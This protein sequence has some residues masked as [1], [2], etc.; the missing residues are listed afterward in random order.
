[1]CW[2]RCG[3][4][5]LLAMAAWGRA[6][7]QDFYGV[8]DSRESTDLMTRLCNAGRTSRSIITPTG[9]A[10]TATQYTIPADTG[11]P[12]VGFNGSV[13]FDVPAGP[14]T[15][16]LNT[17]GDALTLTAPVSVKTTASGTAR[18]VQ[19]GSETHTFALKTSVENQSAFRPCPAAPAG[20]PNQA[21]VTLPPFVRAQG[22]GDA[23]GL[24]VNA[25]CPISDLVIVA[26]SKKLN[27]A[28]AVI[29]FAVQIGVVA[30]LG[31]DG[32]PGI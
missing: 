6:S 24:V 12:A 15:G 18:V 27:A 23:K 16:R 11:C 5:A 17:T 4:A 25:T 3:R 26:G 8:R 9:I 30:E 28:G 1:M 21:T 13:T 10:V 31:T 32:G 7:A 14:L 29:E 19:D 2:M 22:A 20:D